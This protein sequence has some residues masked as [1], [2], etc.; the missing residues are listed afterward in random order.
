MAT[1]KIGAEQWRPALGYE[2]AYQVSTHGRVRSLT[3]MVPT[4]HG[5]ERIQHGRILK[6]RTNVQ[7]GYPLVIL[8]RD[9]VKKV[10]HVHSMV[11]EAFIGPQP[12]GMFVNHIDNERTNN[13]VS[14]LEYV[15]PGENT[16][17][18]MEAGT[19]ATGA[20]RTQAKLD[21]AKVRAIRRRSR[22]GA[23]HNRLAQDYGVSRTLV[24]LVIANKRW[25]E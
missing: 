24:S 1:L 10:R 19:F 20:A 12:E 2:G 16:R 14:N 17:H 15:T 7:T 23:T 13:H 9:G 4:C 18:A 5:S 3:R 25:V 21:W 8:S 22:E 6:Y 11:A